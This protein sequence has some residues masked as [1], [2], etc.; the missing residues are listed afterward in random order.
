[1]AHRKQTTEIRPIKL[2]NWRGEKRCP[3]AWSKVSA[4]TEGRDKRLGKD[5]SEMVGGGV[6]A[7]ISDLLTGWLRK[8]G[9]GVIFL[10]I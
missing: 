5:Y 7:T 9:K 8:E 2:P 6:Q 4:E 1:V 3:K 10:E